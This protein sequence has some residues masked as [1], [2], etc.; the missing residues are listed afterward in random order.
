M[1]CVFRVLPDGAQVV[2][3]LVA[4][5]LIMVMGMA[6]AATGSLLL[7]MAEYLPDA[8]SRCADATS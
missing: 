4:S 5:A 8:P 2:S 7:L 1:M 3:P 6:L